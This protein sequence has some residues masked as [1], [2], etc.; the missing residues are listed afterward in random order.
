MFGS[1]EYYIREQEEIRI[2]NNLEAII[3]III[4]HS[5]KNA[6]EEK[7]LAKQ[8]YG[9]DKYRADEKYSLN[10]RI[11]S[12][13]WKSLRTNVKG[14]KE[15]EG[16]VGY[17]L[18]HLVKHLKKTIPKGYNWQDFLDGKLHIDHIIPKKV[19]NFTEPE[20]TDFKRCWALEN[21]RLLPAR[22]NIIKNAKLIKPF[23]TALF[24]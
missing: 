7:R 4:E 10:S 1:K 14:K 16:K 19:F 24:L 13:I 18:K 15:W 22:E 21:L 5:I 11:S 9:R 20:H 23:Q 12:T 6:K 8:N 2:K 17:T 3:E